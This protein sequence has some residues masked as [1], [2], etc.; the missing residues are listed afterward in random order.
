MG[1]DENIYEVMNR[2]LPVTAAGGPFDFGARGVNDTPRFVSSDPLPQRDNHIF[3]V[4][5]T[6]ANLSSSSRRPNARNASLSEY[7]MYVE[8]VSCSMALLTARAAAKL[9]FARRHA[10][11][12]AKYKAQLP[13]KTNNTSH[14]KYFLRANCLSALQ[15]DVPSTLNYLF[16]VSKPSGNYD[17]PGGPSRE[18]S[19]LHDNL[20]M[21]I[22]A[23]CAH[24]SV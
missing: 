21:D 4:P 12:W 22:K 3:R 6:I 1:L 18:V 23:L 17:A 5:T 24:R 13:S 10:T 16:Q 11:T 8:D 7:G 14:A 19:S 15:L 20:R 2:D 9:A